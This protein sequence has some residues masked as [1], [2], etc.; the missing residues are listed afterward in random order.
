MITEDGEFKPWMSQFKTLGS[1]YKALGKVDMDLK[2]AQYSLSESSFYLKSI[3]YIYIF[4]YLKYIIHVFWNVKL[5]IKCLYLSFVNICF[6]I[7]NMTNPLTF[8][9]T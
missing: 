9:V 5:L 1:A 8:L 7:N 3:I 6:S 4:F 2:L